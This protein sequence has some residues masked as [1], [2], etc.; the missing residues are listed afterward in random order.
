MRAIGELIIR[1]KK[2]LSRKWDEKSIFFAFKKIIKEEYGKIGE[3][4]F[5]PQLL[6]NKKLFV[7]S[8]N[9]AWAGD[10]WINRGEIIRKINQ[11]LGSEEVE[12]IKLSQ[13]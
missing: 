6:K 2:G 13:N 9:S 5:S 1:A 3:F 4:H 10:L 8:D 11:E 7:K 12:E